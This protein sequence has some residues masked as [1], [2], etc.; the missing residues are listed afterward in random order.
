MQTWLPIGIGLLGVF[1]GLGVMLAIPL[2]TFN[3]FLRV[4]PAPGLTP[5]PLTALRSAF[6][7]FD[8]EPRPWTVRTAPAGG[9]ADFIAEWQ[10]ANA[11]WWDVL[12]RSGLTRSYRVLIRLDEAT[13][14]VRVTEQSGSV[15]WSAGVGG[16]TPAIHWSAS[17]F[18][19][20][21]LFERAREIAYG[22]RDAD[23]PRLDRVVAYDFDPW[24]IKGPI[25]RT[26]LEHGW[27]YAPVVH[28]FQLGSARRA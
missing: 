5:T 11:A 14:E 7:A 2:G 6:L 16:G 27:T 26:A 24:R 19:G 21:V 4:R 25:V 12:Q 8:D 22:M 23:E 17:F 28:A 9:R 10:L 15:R 3:R 13:H 1:A 18:R 20:V